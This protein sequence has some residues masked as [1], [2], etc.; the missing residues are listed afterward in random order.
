[1]SIVW[2]Y[3]DKRAATIDALKDYPSMEFILENTD[4]SIAAEQDKMTSLGSPSFDGLPHAHNPQSGEDKIID[5]IEKIDVLK[6]RYRQAVEYMQW[7]KPAWEE[8]TEDEQFILESFYGT[9]YRDHAVDCVAER[10]NIE[11]SSAYNKKNRALKHL[12]VLLYGKE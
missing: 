6:E 7:F 3:L 1:M 9:E 4:Q 11:R 5:G 8:L 10:F 12:T 2:K